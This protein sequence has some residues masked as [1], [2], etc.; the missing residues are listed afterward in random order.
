MGL[1]SNGIELTT[2]REDGG[3]P[4]MV[5]IGIDLVDVGCEMD[6]CVA[7]DMSWHGGI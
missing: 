4:G 5:A 1:P 3:E 6:V 7:K 2:G